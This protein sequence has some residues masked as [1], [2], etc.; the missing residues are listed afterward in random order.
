MGPGEQCSHHGLDRNWGILR[1]GYP[2][3]C[4]SYWQISLT[5]HLQ[6]DTIFVV[7]TVSGNKRE[8]SCIY[9]PGH[10]KNLFFDLWHGVCMLSHVQLFAIPW[11]VA[12]QALL[13]MEFS[14]QEYWN[15]LPD[16]I[17]TSRR[18]SQPRDL[19]HVSCISCT[20]RQILYHFHDPGSPLLTS[21]ETP[22]LASKAFC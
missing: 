11:T 9:C 17:L 22:F 20:G 19:T 16:A 3:L 8:S 12:H 10:Q 6:R 14:R 15:G 4:R 18:S 13:S 1:W 21:R 5:P 2:D 7:W